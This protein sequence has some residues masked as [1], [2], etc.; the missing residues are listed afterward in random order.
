VIKFRVFLATF[1]R[2]VV[3]VEKRCSWFNEQCSTLSER[4]RF[5]PVMVDEPSVEDTISILRGLR[6]HSGEPA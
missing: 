2:L 6:E 5:H 3:W 4:R 1:S